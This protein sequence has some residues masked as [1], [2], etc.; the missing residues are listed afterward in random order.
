MSRFN[1]RLF[2][3]GQRYSYINIDLLLSIQTSSNQ[4]LTYYCAKDCGG[5]GDRLRGIT[6][7]YILAV[8][9]RRRFLID[10][11]YPCHLSNFLTP[12]LI[13]WQ[14]INSNIKAQEIL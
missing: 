11:Q 6:S 3:L 12:N 13:D 2:R 14:S 4:I 7:T 1:Q 10:M 8:L 5:W 9:L